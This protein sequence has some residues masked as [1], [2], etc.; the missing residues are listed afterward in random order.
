[1]LPEIPTRDSSG[2]ASVGIGCFPVRNT[3]RSYIS[4][5]LI[6]VALG[7][8][9]DLSAAESDSTHF[10]VQQYVVKGSGVLFTNLPKSDFA[11]YTGPNVGVT[12]IVG[13]AS[14]LQAQYE[15]A[16]FPGVSVAT[17]LERITNGIVTLN[18]FRGLHPQILISGRQYPALQRELQVAGQPGPGAKTVSTAKTAAGPAAKSSGTNSPA[19]PKFVVRAYEITGDTLLSTNTLMGIFG[20]RV[21][22]N[23]TIAD[24][25]QGASDL[26]SEYRAR[27][28][29][30]VSVTIPQ[31]QLTNGI[32][33]IRVFEGRI[34]DVLVTGNHYFTSN[35]IM[36]AL[37]SVQI[38]TIL[39]GPIFQ[40]ELD[41]AN[42]N[43][44]R[45]IYPQIEPGDQPNT[46]RLRLEVHD[47]LPVHAKL[48]FNNQNTPG[49]P[50]L[51]LNAS[52]VYDNLWQLEHSI[53]F[54][55]GFSPEA[56]KGGDWPFYD[57]PLV[58]NYSGF[59][60]MPLGNPE[61]LSTAV[62]N[63]PNNFGYSE[64]TRQ[65]RL[66]APS[67]R[68]ELNFYASRSTIDTGLTTPFSANIYNTNG[69]TLDRKDVQ[70]D[71][72]TTADVGTRLTIPVKTTANFQSSF[73]AGPDYK[74]Y[75]LSS[76]KTNVFTLTSIILDTI[77]NPGHVITN[78]NVST[79]YSPVPLTVHSLDYFPLAFRYDATLRDRFGF[80]SFGLGLG[81]NAWYSGTLNNLKAIT[82]S[83]E[84]TGNWVTLLPSMS[85]DFLIHTNW[86]LSLHAEGQWADEPLISNEQFGIGGVNSVRG[87]HE[88]EVFGDTGWRFSSELKSPPQVIGTVYG[89]ALLTVRGSIYMDYGEVYLLDPQGR[90]SRYPLW[91]T[92]FGAMAS[93]GPHFD[94]RFLCSFPLLGTT[95]TE[96]YQPR[97]NFGLSAQF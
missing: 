87:Y 89:K 80:T 4:I 50:E 47:R 43:Q 26:Q 52:A 28:Y 16:G 96:A 19:T 11:A 14:E 59:Y 88:G 84:S 86:T 79:V 22:T 17:A 58:A 66:P 49:T 57:L 95:T 67:G 55:Y 25:T 34:S 90:S 42:A 41:R 73:S 94:V 83:K 23:V 53:G 78:I 13:A 38:G 32:V 71:L 39:S 21:G 20:K 18:V 6:I 91:G 92:G 64:A 63:N 51:R 56:Y 12:Q 30:T 1:M 8:S 54:Q 72:T 68:S 44:N 45:Q 81:V 37:P 15:A 3:S 74:T 33:K 76:A 46:S 82:G 77:S 97:F 60:R 27:G 10:E 7:L 69:N 65:F 2:A 29:P 36:R 93:I 40:A 61:P 75:E 62:A 9:F 24:I 70:Q 85:R 35:N 5:C 31:Q 48:D